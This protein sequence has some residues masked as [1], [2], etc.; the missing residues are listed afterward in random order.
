MSD[1]IYSAVGEI[2]KQETDSIRVELEQVQDAVVAA[3]ETGLAEL[4]LKNELDHQA[5]VLLKQVR[6]VRLNKPAATNLKD[7][8]TACRKVFAR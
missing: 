4:A 2:I 5:A 1:H 7:I 3:R 8:P 6:S